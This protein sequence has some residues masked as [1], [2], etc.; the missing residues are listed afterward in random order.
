M[1]SQRPF[2]I[3]EASFVNEVR[4][5]LRQWVAV[6]GL[7][8]IVVGSTPRLWTHSER[9]DTDSDYRIPY[10][11]SKDYWLYQRWLEKS[12]RSDRIF[13]VG[14]SVV[15]GEYVRPDGTLSHFLN[16]EFGQRSGFIN[17]GVNGLFP[18]ALEG[19][20][21]NYGGALREKKVVLHCNVLWMSSP[22]A[23]LQTAKEEK[24]NH[25][26]LVPQFRPWIPCYKADVSDRIGILVEQRL[27]LLA[28]VNHL[29][30]A[31]FDQKNIL[32]WTLAEDGQDPPHYT[33][34]YKNP[35]AQI[36][37]VVPSEAGTDPE[38]GISSARHKAWSTSG[39]GT[40][41]F[42]WVAVDTSLQWAAFQRLTRMLIDRGNDVL[43]LI[44]TFNEHMLAPENKPGFR[45]L[46]D[47]MVEWFSKNQIPF[48]QP[49]VLPSELYADASHPLTEGY[50]RLANELFSLES[51]RTW[52]EKPAAD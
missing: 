27:P 2:E 15:W 13:V 41:R 44:G 49:D 16:K 5:N 25:S 12:A 32:D 31:Y 6:F 40:A 21:R 35:L 19:L 39:R 23:D 18:L 29:Q 36:T 52:A 43:V 20:I 33:N 47:G 7:V 11:L 26:R 45:E 51:F 46:R 38:R 9:F 50:A 4:L 48:V 17:A 30:N 10:S 8:A 22:K 3:P 14:D 42:E 37:F 34:S 24:F 28:W 1:K